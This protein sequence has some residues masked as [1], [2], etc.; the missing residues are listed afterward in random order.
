MNALCIEALNWYYEDYAIV[1]VEPHVYRTKLWQLSDVRISHLQS[2]LNFS[3]GSPMFE[4]ICQAAPAYAFVKANEA[5]GRNEKGIYRHDF[6]KGTTD[7]YD[8]KAYEAWIEKRPAMTIWC[9]T[10]CA[11]S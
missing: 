8:P 5:G 10:L 1:T 4:Q 7:G 2:G 11:I 6:E 3:I 9:Q